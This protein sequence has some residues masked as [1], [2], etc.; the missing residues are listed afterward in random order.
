[1]CGFWGAERGERPQKG[2]GSAMAKAAGGPEV[3]IGLNS[4]SD[5]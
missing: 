3:T 4:V 5:T 1:M 2:E